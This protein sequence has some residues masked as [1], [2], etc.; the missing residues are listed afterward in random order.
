MTQGFEFGWMPDESWSGQKKPSISATKFGDGYEQRVSNGIN[1]TP[2]QFK[3]KF[4][5]STLECIGI[6]RF[7]SVMNGKNSFEWRNPLGIKNNYICK[8]WNVSRVNAA[9]LSVSATFD[10]V[11]EKVSVPS[12]DYDMAG[13][14]EK[15]GNIHTIGT[16]YTDEFKLQ[17]HMTF[18][19]ESLF[20]TDYIRGGSWVGDDSSWVFYP[21]EYNFSRFSNSQYITYFLNNED[22]LSAVMLSTGLAHGGLS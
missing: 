6:D 8:E 1:N 11:F 20:S 4:T 7:L 13:Y 19:D 3:L 18:S 17:N 15:Y 21:S 10:Q 12:I 2:K 9:V 16:H 14:N 5:K 22:S